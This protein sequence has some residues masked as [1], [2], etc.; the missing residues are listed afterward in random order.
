MS[1]SYQQL[2]L[3]EESS[4]VVTINTQGLFQNT[5]LLFR[6]LSKNSGESVGGIDHT[7]VYLDDILLT[8]VTEE[9][10][11]KKNS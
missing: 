7:A 1:H 10:H 2:V 11:L 4:K 6:D 5:H 9:D 8:G 3:A